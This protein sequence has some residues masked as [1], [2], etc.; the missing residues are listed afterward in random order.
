MTE[1]KAVLSEPLVW[2]DKYYSER[3][4]LT[5]LFSRRLFDVAALAR[6]AATRSP[7]WWLTLTDREVPRD[8][9]HDLLQ[10]D[11][12]HRVWCWQ[13][14]GE[15]LYTPSS[16]QETPCKSLMLNQGPFLNRVPQSKYITETKLSLRNYL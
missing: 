15:Q 6:L 5:C 16:E 7:Y 3:F 1:W 4:H 10:Q 8:V 2:A 14:S 11:E 12:R 13:R 9:K